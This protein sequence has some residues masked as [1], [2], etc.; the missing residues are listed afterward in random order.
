[1]SSL[2]WSFDWWKCLHLVWPLWQHCRD[3]CG[4]S[5]DASFTKACFEELHRRIEPGR[6][7]ALTFSTPHRHSTWWCTSIRNLLVG[8]GV[9]CLPHAKRMTHVCHCLSIGSVIYNLE[10][11]IGNNCRCIGSSF[12]D[13]W[14]GLFPGATVEWCWWV[15][16]LVWVNPS[17]TLIH[18][19]KL[20]WPMVYRISC[21][22]KT[23]TVKTPWRQPPLLNR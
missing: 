20:R 8:H 2:C 21:R 19:W 14:V 4:S 9:S 17:R 1:M 3:F 6:H 15:L 13:L 22:W 16:P 18:E 23:S 5:K 12:A 10:N 7:V 11:K